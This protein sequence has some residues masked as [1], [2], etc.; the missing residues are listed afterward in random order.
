MT[1]SI[2]HSN[3][4]NNRNTDPWRGFHAGAW[5]TCVDVRNF[6]QTN[7]QP[8]LGGANFL[9]P[10]EDD[11]RDV[12]MS[13]ALSVA[14]RAAGL[15]STNIRSV[16][17]ENRRAEARLDVSE[18]HWPQINAARDAG[19]LHGMP[20]PM[21][22]S[23]TAA[24]CRRVALYGVDFLRAERRQQLAS[25]N[26]GPFTQ[27]LMQQRRDLSEQMLALEELRDVALAQGWTSTARRRTR[28]KPC[29][30]WRS[31]PWPPLVRMKHL[32]SPW[33]AFRRFSMSTFSA[34]WTRAF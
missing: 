15:P 3:S 10:V 22:R 21:S 17:I 34:T 26:Q 28:T 14:L 18:L 2:A 24:D 13:F 6:L 20:E 29:S 32:H 5:K 9:V 23:A 25:L 8:Y 4:S 11:V 16:R 33:G 7:V 12:P 30:G 27:A 1:D 31:Q 19:L